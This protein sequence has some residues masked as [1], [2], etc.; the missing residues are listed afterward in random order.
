MIYI[1]IVKILSF[2]LCI[3]IWHG[4]EFCF[5]YQHHGSFNAK[6]KQ[7]KYQFRENSNDLNLKEKKMYSLYLFIHFLILMNNVVFFFN[8]KFASSYKNLS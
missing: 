1:Y 3:F 4:H 5:F 8:Q 7:W 2:Y 6:L